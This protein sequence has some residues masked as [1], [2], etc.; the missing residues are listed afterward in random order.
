MPRRLHRLLPVI[1]LL[2]AGVGAPLASQDAPADSTRLALARQLLVLN[3]STEQAMA[4]MDAMLT[5]QRA[6]NPRIPGAFWD[7]FGARVHESRDTF[8]GM[9]AEIY[10]RHFTASELRELIAFHQTPIG[11]RLIELQPRISQESMEAG[12]QWGA[13][14]GQAVAAQLEA[15]GVTLEP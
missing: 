14:I 15:E 12:Q 1:A 8:T 5:S 7:R 2:L 9:L 6:L 4:N 3:R 11:Q 10:A 13:R